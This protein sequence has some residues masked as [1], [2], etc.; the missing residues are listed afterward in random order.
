MQER[1][2]ELLDLLDK[3]KKDAR[4]I[5]KSMEDVF[6]KDFPPRVCVITEALEDKLVKLLDEVFNQELA[7]YYLYDCVNLSTGE[8]HG[9]I[10][11]NGKDFPLRNIDDIKHYLDYINE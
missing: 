8:R 10:V 9:R 7:S 6:G 1:A 2:I 3:S 4:Q 5:N 11:L